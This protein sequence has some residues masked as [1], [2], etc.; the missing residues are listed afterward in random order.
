[1]TASIYMT[2]AVAV[3][4]Y[5]DMR[6]TGSNILIPRIESGIWQSIIV[7]VSAAL[8]N[9]PRWFEFEYNYEMK[10]VNLTMVNGTMV[11]SNVSDIVVGTTELRRN[12]AYVRDYTLIAN[13]VCVL[14]LPTLIMLISTF[15]IV[16]QMI[17][18]KSSIYTCNQERARKKRNRSITLMLIGIIVLFFV[19]HIGEVIISMYEMIL[20]IDNGEKVEFPQLIRNLIVL[21]HLLIVMNSSL[22]FAIYCKDLVF[23]ECAKKFYAK[24]FSEPSCIPISAGTHRILQTNQQMQRPLRRVQISDDQDQCAPPMPTVVVQSGK[25]LV[26]QTCDESTSDPMKIDGNENH[27]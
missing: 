27:S 3:N 22:N 7:F 12:E 16:R 14:L 2:V 21:N 1:M 20:F 25:T 6:I 18:P 23:R 24:I 13:T 9:L 15:L 8:F 10:E 11:L 5:M 26:T 4:R 19:C 17:L